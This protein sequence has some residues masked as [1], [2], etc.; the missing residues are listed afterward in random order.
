M[1]LDIEAEKSR[2]INSLEVQLRNSEA[3]E[4][5]LHEKIGMLTDNFG[6]LEEHI[7]LMKERLISADL[8]NDQLEKQLEMAEL[9]LADCDANVNELK[10][11]EIRFRTDLERH[12]RREIRGERE[13]NELIGE[14]ERL[15][16][17]LNHNRQK[18][19]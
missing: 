18:L 19:H 12:Q 5:S 4:R 1:L 8:R 16:G 10:E 14:N 9:K 11:F 6:S 2:N 15:F 7:S 13:L 3:K 17:E